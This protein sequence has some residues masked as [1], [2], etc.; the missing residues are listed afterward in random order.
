MTTTPRQPLFCAHADTNGDPGRCACGQQLADVGPA[1]PPPPW[2]EP[3]TEPIWEQL[4]ER[5]GGVTICQWTRY[6]P[7]GDPVAADVWI[8]ADDRVVDGRVLRTQPAIH[9]TEPPVLGIGPAAAR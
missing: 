4:T 2:C 5:Y 3:G 9:Y 1:T 7:A 8:A 6:F